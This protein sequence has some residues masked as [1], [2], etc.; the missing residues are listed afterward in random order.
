MLS[1][2]A[3]PSFVD[4]PLVEV[5]LAVNFDPL[6]KLS[7]PHLGLLWDEYRDRFPL[8][9]H[10][11]PVDLVIERFGGKASPVSN[12]GLQLSPMPPMP[13]LW[14]V[15]GSGN[16]LIQVQG[17]M[18]GRNWRKVKDGERYPRYKDS[19][20]PGFIE[21]YKV[22]E[23]Y[24]TKNDLGPMNPNQCSVTYVNHIGSGTTWE[25]H[26]QIANVFKLW[27]TNPGGTAA[28]EVE[29]IK[30]AIRYA[31]FDDNGEFVGRLHVSVEPA[32]RKKGEEPIFLVTLTARGRPLGA[33]LEGAIGFMDLGRHHIVN[34]FDT[35]TTDEMHKLWEPQ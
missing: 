22:F 32:F 18:F 15:D 33:G 11:P 27:N 16:N 25:K 28:L 23:E 10:H 31:I 13:R 35:L 26:S 34:T 19:V 17:D 30:F 5:A 9:E 7:V 8:V 12:F 2:D 1:S 3:L 21:D 6:P 14:F 24:L 20:R 4:P 29:D